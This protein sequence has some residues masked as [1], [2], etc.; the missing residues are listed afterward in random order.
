MVGLG[1]GAGQSIH[2]RGNKEDERRWYI[3]GKMQE[4]V[5]MIKGN[6]SAGH[7]FVLKDLIPMTFLK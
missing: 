7:C 3:F 2:G 6:N 5:G 4:T 1:E